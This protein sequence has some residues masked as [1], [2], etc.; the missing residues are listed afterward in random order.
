MVMMFTE[1]CRKLNNATDADMDVMMD[2]KIPETPSA[3]CTMTCTLK[4][5]KLV[6]NR[7]MYISE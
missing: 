2:G 6:I 7:L 1:N 5:L 4:E 3:K